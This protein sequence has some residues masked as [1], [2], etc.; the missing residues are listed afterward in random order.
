MAKSMALPRPRQR[1]ASERHTCC[2]LAPATSHFAPALCAASLRQSFNAIL[3]G[4]PPQNFFC[5]VWPCDRSARSLL[6]SL[7]EQLLQSLCV[8]HMRNPPLD[9]TIFLVPV[10]GGVRV[11]RL[12]SMNGLASPVPPPASVL[13]QTSS[14]NASCA[15]FLAAA[16][17]VQVLSC[18]FFGASSLRNYS[19]KLSCASFL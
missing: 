17:L 4:N 8:I 19:C 9:C 2:A 12:A 13:A 10:C 16:V 1:T 15:C 11:V 6:G 7:A 3:P 18:N 14:C 5:A